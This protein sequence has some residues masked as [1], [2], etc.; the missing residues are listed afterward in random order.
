MAGGH[1]TGLAWAGISNAWEEVS[2]YREASIDDQD[3][4]YY[5]EAH[6]YQQEKRQRLLDRIREEERRN[7]IY[8]PE[9]QEAKYE[10][11]LL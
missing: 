11:L 10:D 1:Q 8:H 3:R 7:G 9:D 4:I 2:V 6:R 5:F